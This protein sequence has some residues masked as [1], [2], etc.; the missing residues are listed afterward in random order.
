[1]PFVPPSEQ[2][3]TNKR[4]RKLLMNSLIL[5]C[6]I[7][8]QCFHC[9]LF[10]FFAI[11]LFVQVYYQAKRRFCVRPLDMS[12]YYFQIYVQEE[13][14]DLNS[15]IFSNLGVIIQNTTLSL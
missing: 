6:Y 4:L 14:V 15:L 5:Q 13:L 10:Y 1:M 8:A 9:Y 7:Q 2:A 12:L 11:S 3:T